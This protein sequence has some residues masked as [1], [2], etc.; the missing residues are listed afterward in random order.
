VFICCFLAVLCSLFQRWLYFFLGV[1]AIYQLSPT[2]G[3]DGRWW[4]WVF[5][6]FFRLVLLLSC[7]ELVVV[8]LLLRVG[9]L[10]L[11]LLDVLNFGI[12][13]W[14]LE[15]PTLHVVIGVGFCGG[16]AL[17]EDV[18]DCLWWW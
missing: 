4:T 1:P 17:F 11:Q 6:P 18:R 10:S 5:D 8:M 13:C 3:H 12:W 2:V 15:K 16:L 14:I 7:S 9:S